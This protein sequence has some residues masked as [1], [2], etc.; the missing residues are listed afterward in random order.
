MYFFH[1]LL[2]TTSSTQCAD[3]LRS[4]ALAEEGERAV[5]ASDGALQLMTALR[6]FPKDSTLHVAVMAAI[7]NCTSRPDSRRVFFGQDL[8]RQVVAIL[9]NF[10]YVTPVQLHGSCITLYR[11]KKNNLRFHQARP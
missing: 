2:P 9:R 4:M 7:V 8:V 10:S 5:V 11:E 3:L 1:V 6:N